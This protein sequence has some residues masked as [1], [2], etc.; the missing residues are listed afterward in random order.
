MFKS[1][2]NLKNDIVK[3]IYDYLQTNYKDIYFFMGK[4]SSWG[5]SDAIASINPSEDQSFNIYKDLVLLYNINPNNISLGCDRIDWEEKVFPMYSKTNVSNNIH[6]ITDEYNIYKC[7][8]NNSEAVS[9]N[10]PTHKTFSVPREADGYMWKYLY[11]LSDK[12]ISLFLSDTKIPVQYYDNGTSNSV[13]TELNA[14]PGTIDSYKIISAGSGY[15]YVTATIVGDGTD[16]EITLTVNKDTNTLE[17]PNVVNAGKNYT[18]AEVII[19]T[20]GVG[21]K[22]EPIISPKLG[23]GSNIV[24]ELNANCVIV[25]NYTATKAQDNINV[26]K[27]FDYRKVGLISNLKSASAANSISNCYRIVVANSANFANSDKITINNIKG[28]LV[29][30]TSTFV[31]QTFFINELEKNI[32]IDSFAGAT[33]KSL[34]SGAETTILSC[35]Y[36]PEINDSFNILHLENISK[37][38]RYEYTLDIVKIIIDF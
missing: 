37:K 24:K 31:T 3:S 25:S 4:S 6:I 10:K 13:I 23:H 16:A 26:P 15:T 1:S 9:L 33:I 27:F 34:A 18:W 17:L 32:D 14:I 36:V 30:K 20:D 5:P 8:D 35:E 29:S 12:D 7:V 2:Q 22:I 11:T 28:T 19:Q 38:Q 21:I